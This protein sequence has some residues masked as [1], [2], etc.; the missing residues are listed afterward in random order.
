MDKLSSQR[1]AAQSVRVRAAPSIACLPEGSTDALPTANSTEPARIRPDHQ[2]RLLSI[3]AAHPIPF[4]PHLAHHGLPKPAATPASA[5]TK[6]CPVRIPLAPT[7]SAPAIK[8][9]QG[10]PLSSRARSAPVFSLRLDHGPR[11][12]SCLL[13][14]AELFLSFLL[15]FLPFLS[16]QSI[17]IGSN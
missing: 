13:A 15:P 17:T 11:A 6:P 3:S 12:L 7:A 5:T 9:P 16:I 8:V 1:A 14:F 10:A 2:S 4:R